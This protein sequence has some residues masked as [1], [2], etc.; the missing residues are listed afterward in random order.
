VILGS[1]TCQACTVMTLHTRMC[2]AVSG[3]AHGQECGHGAG[4][5]LVNRSGSVPAIHSSEPRPESSRPRWTTSAITE[6]LP[7]KSPPDQSAKLELAD[8]GGLVSRSNGRGVFARRDGRFE[9]PP[10]FPG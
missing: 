10:A 9:M 8:T 7:I 3:F 1:G 2:C 6:G 4:A 5:A